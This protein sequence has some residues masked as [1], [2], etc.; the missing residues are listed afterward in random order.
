MQVEHPEKHKICIVTASL[1]AVT[2]IQEA[3]N[4][5]KRHF[6]IGKI[7]DQI[8][9]M[10]N[11][12][13]DINICWVPSHQ[14]IKGNERADNLAQEAINFPDKTHNLALHFSELPTTLMVARSEKWQ[15]QWNNSEKGRMCHSILPKIQ[16]KPW[17][18]GTYLDRPTIVFWN[19]IISNHTRS[20]DSLNRNGIVQ[21]PIC[22]CG[23]NYQTIDHLLF[24]CQETTDKDMKRKLRGLGY[25][26][27]WNIRD[28]IACEVLKP[29]KPRMKIIGEAMAEMLIEE[30][31]I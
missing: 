23:K 11:N 25:H 30:K 22:S 9:S 12:G 7:L 14:G 21:S 29:D 26:P 1:S 27:P 2:A 6:I 17:Y 28:I 5:H 13:N 8:E 20:K 10:I 4:L 19:R 16:P 15:T 3:S 18:K 31:K 24:E